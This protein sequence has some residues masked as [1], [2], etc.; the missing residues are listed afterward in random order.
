MN[1]HEVIG[2]VYKTFSY[3]DFKILKGNRDVDHIN[4]IKKSM[5]DNGPLFNPILVNENMEILDGQNR[6][7]ASKELGLPIY[8]VI[9]PGYGVKE[10]R[11]LN[12]NSKNWTFHDYV[13]SYAGEGI[14]GYIDLK[15]LIDMFPELPPNKVIHIANGKLSND[16]RVG[17]DKYNKGNISDNVNSIK[18]GVYQV[19]D[20]EKAISIGNM[21][22]EYKGLDDNERPIFKR[23]EFISAIIKLSRCVD[24]DND[25]V[26]RKIKMYPRTFVPCISSDEYIRMIEGIVNFKRKQ[27]IR[28]NV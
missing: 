4:S 27:K 9:R 21:I 15:K 17:T 3:D 12:R 10:T 14:Q 13:K 1:T 22:M 18:K 28:Y 8:Y 16:S 25:E 5:V 11:I 24:F 23:P 19:K 26:I 7:Y 20:M 2:H 6:F